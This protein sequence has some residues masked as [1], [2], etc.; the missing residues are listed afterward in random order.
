[1]TRKNMQELIHCFFVA[2]KFAFFI[3]FENFFLAGHTNVSGM[4]YYIRTHMPCFL[5]IFFFRDGKPL[6]C[7]IKI[8]V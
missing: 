1:M 6:F 4:F 3:L 2:N 8:A 5:F 7:C